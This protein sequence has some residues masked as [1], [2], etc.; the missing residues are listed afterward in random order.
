M[1]LHPTAM[2]V[3][4]P[5]DVLDKNVNLPSPSDQVEAIINFNYS[6]ACSS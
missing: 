3:L 6:S 1:K 5:F 2:L 4:L